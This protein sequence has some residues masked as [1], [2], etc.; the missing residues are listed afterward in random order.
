MGWGYL[1][2][3]PNEGCLKNQTGHSIKMSFERGKS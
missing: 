2:I 1:G 3:A